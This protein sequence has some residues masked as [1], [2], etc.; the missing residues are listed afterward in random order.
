M[1]NYLR[2]YQIVGLSRCEEG[3]RPDEA[4]SSFYAIL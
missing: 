2:L 1:N 3:V 4:I